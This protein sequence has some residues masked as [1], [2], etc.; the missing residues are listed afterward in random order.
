[1]KYLGIDEEVLKNT[2]SYNTAFEI[3][4]QPDLWLKTVEK[5]ESIKGEIKEFLKK[6][7]FSSEFDVLFTGAGTSEYV[8]NIL[9]P[10]FNEKS[11]INFKSVASTDIVNNPEIY[12]KKN[13]KTLLISFARSGDSPE[14]VASVELADK[15]ID[16]VYHIFITCNKEGHLAKISKVND[17]AF[18]FLMP[19]GTND[20]GFAMTSSFSCMVLAAML[21]FDKVPDP[22]KTIETARMGLT[23]RLDEVKRLAE[24]DHKRI[25]VLGSGV[26][27]GLAHE[28]TLKVMELSAGLVVAKF[29]TVL[30][31]R[32]GPK[33]IVNKDTIVFICNAVN[34][35]ARKY[36]K[37][38]FE[39][40]YEEKIAKNLVSYTLDKDAIKSVSTD[41]IYPSKVLIE[42]DA[43]A[44]F[45]YLIYG[46]MYA[47][48]K[49]QFLGLTTDNPFPSGEVNRVVKK[50]KIHKY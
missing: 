46:Q 26:F 2:N 27:K 8:G 12:L 43:T 23:E 37:G 39:E 34:K 13:R 18:L 50:F 44:I 38:L 42:D 11:N 24:I 49:S 31:F 19:D 6:I 48:F 45:T 4:Q 15:L 47:F 5:Y 41:C 35:Y 22:K 30:G 28:L 3:C 21:I 10:M 1:M 36:D 33:S 20:K 17:N 32:H 7:N 16:N 40:M 29:D 25:V 14:S 9:E